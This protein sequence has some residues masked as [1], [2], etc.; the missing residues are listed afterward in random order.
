MEFHF[1]RHIRLRPKM[2]NAFRSA[3]SIGL[4]HK[5][6]LILVLVLQ[7]RLGLDLDTGA[8]PDGR[9]GGGESLP[10]SPLSLLSPPLPLLPF[11]C[12]PSPSLLSLPFPPSPFPPPFP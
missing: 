2:K 11:P 3:S 6:V 7:S 5:K 8:D 4:H 12:S 10:P 1:R 9:L